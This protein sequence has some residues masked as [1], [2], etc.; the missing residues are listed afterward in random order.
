MNP[1]TQLIDATLLIGGVPIL[2]REIIGNVFGLASAIGGM[3][4]VVWA[5]PIGIIGNLL[6][7]TVFLGGVFHTPQN[8]DL[9]G[10]AGRQVMFLIV[11]LYGWITW[12]A[13]KRRGVRESTETN[14]SRSIISEP[15]EDSAAV[16]PHWATP[17]E[18]IAMLAFAVASTLGCAWVFAALGSWGPLADAWIFTGS[19]LATYGMARG[20]TE[21]W[22]IWIAVDIVGV[23]L[24]LS[25]GYYPS[26]MLY[27]I[28]GAFVIWGFTVWL[29]VQ[30]RQRQTAPEPRQE[31][32]TVV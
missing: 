5:W 31:H 26:A 14:P 11:S 1:F 4:R 20:W 29:R 6:L 8:L 25:A 32:Y 30:R 12:A 21:F 9:Y 19:I 7:F 23:P 10:Q 24:L 3:K 13:A 18:R 28:Y 16:Q 17:R 15:K 2:W 27:V 22:L